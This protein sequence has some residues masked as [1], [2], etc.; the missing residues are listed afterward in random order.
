MVQEQSLRQ[1]TNIGNILTF[2]TKQIGFNLPTDKTLSPTA[3]IPQQIKIDPLFSF[4]KIGISSGGLYYV[5][6]PNLVVLDG[7]TNQVDT[8]VELKYN[9]NDSEVTIIKNT[10]GLNNTPQDRDWET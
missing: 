2:E 3:N 1:S 7:V 10:F 8:N 6:A 9:L 4:E 5:K